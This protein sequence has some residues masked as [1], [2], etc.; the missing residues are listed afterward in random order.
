M[1]HKL[2]T[3]FGIGLRLNVVKILYL[4]NVNVFITKNGLNRTFTQSQDVDVS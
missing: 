4:R 3:T 2:T 1:L